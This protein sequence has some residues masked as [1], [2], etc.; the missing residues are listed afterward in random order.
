VRLRLLLGLALGL[1][2][3]PARAVPIGTASFAS[4]RIESF[5]HL[6]PG[7]SVGRPTGL[8][9]VFLP[10][11]G[12]PYRFASGVTLVGPSVDVFPA[13][14]FVH[15]LR[16]GG[17]PPN[18]WGANGT[19]DDAGDVLM[20]SAYLA[21]FQA[22]TREA[23]I[24]LT[25][26]APQA[27]VGAF[28]TG[29]AGSTITLE[30]YG[31]GGVLLESATA[32]AVPIDRWIDNF[33]GLERREGIERIV[34]RGHDLGLDA[35]LFDDTFAASVPEPA[36]LLLFTAGVAALAVRRPLRARA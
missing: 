21:V 6:T 33:L 36:T 11:N 31:A 24:E 19:I 16:A 8:S 27:R 29:E 1:C 13:D 23:S 3:V 17:A 2:A 25:F 4:F 34:F 18:D 7:P 32:S 22:G 26:D 28:V 12:T 5:E 30:V 20:G 9:G 14:P 15:D 10:G 35:L